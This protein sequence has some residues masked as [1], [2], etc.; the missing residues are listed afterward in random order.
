[1]SQALETVAEFIRRISAS[2]E[3]FPG[4][5]NPAIFFSGKDEGTLFL[6]DEEAEQ[7]GECLHLLIDAVASEKIRV[8]WESRGY[9]HMW[10]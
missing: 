1:M 10:G 2:I 3:E 5:T 6:D 9:T 7:Y 4:R 8:L